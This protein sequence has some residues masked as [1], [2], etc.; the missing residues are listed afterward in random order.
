MA[1]KE[2]PYKIYLEESE[3]PRQWYNVRADM[4]NK[5][6][7][8]DRA[9]EIPSDLLE[10]ELTETIL[11]DEFSGAKQLIDRL[12]AYGYRA[13]AYTHLIKRVVKSGLDVCDFNVVLDEAHENHDHDMEYLYG[14]GEHVHEGHSHG[15]H[16]GHHHLSLIHIYA[17][18]GE[19]P[20]G[21][22]GIRKGD[23]AAV[24]CKRRIE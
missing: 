4:K 16:H 15:E 2:I 20:G 1:N 5:M 6:C 24:Y 3:M 18:E 14:N 7:I 22:E 11:L 8:R 17:D 23:E 10:F 21:A 19:I 12:R 13:V 9:Y